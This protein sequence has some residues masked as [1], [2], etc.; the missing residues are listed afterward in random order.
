MPSFHTVSLFGRADSD[1]ATSTKAVSSSSSTSTSS[2]SLTDLSGET[3][4]S[5]EKLDA[6]IAIAAVFGLA[7]VYLAWLLHRAKKRTYAARLGETMNPFAGVREK[8]DGAV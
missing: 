7:T 5:N 6:V 1:A 2:G 8:G 4:W 3:C